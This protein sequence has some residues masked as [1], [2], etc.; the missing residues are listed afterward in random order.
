LAAM[1]SLPFDPG[2]GVAA[3]DDAGAMA[4]D[5]P[6]GWNVAVPKSRGISVCA[7]CLCEVAAGSVRV[8]TGGR[9]A[10]VHHVGCVASRLGDVSLMTGWSDL[11][12]S[13]QEAA[14]TA[15]ET[16]LGNGAGGIAAAL[17][18][19]PETEV[20]GPLL[21]T[22]QPLTAEG[23]KLLNLSFW[24]S[25]P[26]SA[27]HDPVRTGRSVPPWLHRA[28]AELRGAAA[29]ALKEAASAS[30]TEREWKALLFLDRLLFAVPA[31][32]RAGRRGQSGET[33]SQTLSR[34]LRSAWAGEWHV[35][36]QESAAAISTPGTAESRAAR[37]EVSADIR[38]IEATMAEEDVRCALRR[39]DG[40]LAFASTQDALRELPGLFPAAE[41]ALP[42]PDGRQPAALDVQ[43]FLEE[44]DKAF[45]RAP[46][47]RAPGPGGGRNEHWHFMPDYTP[48]WEPLQE[49]WLNLSLGRVPPNVLAA[50]AGARVLAGDK[51]GGKVRP[52]ALGHTLRRLLARSVARVFAGR[53]GEAVRP[54]NY[55]LGMPSGAEAM[56]KSVLCDLARR[57]AANLDSFDVT[58][59]H[60]EVERA[61]LIEAV[62]ESVPDL[63][64]WVE[65]WLR[66]EAVH[67]CHLPG[68]SPVQLRKNRGGDQGDPLINLLFPLAFHRVCLATQEVAARHDSEAHVYA[69]QDD[70]QLVATCDARPAAKAAFQAACSELGLRP[71]E[72]KEEL[73]MGPAADSVADVDCTVVSRPRVLRHGGEQEIPATRDD[74]APPGSLLADTAPE[75]AKLLANRTTFLQRLTSLHNAGLSAQLTLGLLRYRTAGDFTFLARA[76]GIPVAAAQKLDSEVLQFVEQLVGGPGWD[77]FARRR[78]FHPLKDGGL[79]IASVELVAA[80]AHSASWCGVA[81]EVVNRLGLPSVA[82]LRA[83]VP[84]AEACLAVAEAL[85]AN[86]SGDPLEPATAQTRA[87]ALSQKALT[88]ARVKN[89]VAE[90]FRQLEGDPPAAAQLHSSGG[91]GAAGW[92]LSPKRPAHYFRDEQLSVAIRLRLGLAVPCAQGVCQHVKAGGQVCGAVLDTRGLH[93][94]TCQAGG[95]SIRRHDAACKCVAA[96]AEL[97]GCSAEREVVLPLAA[98]TRP[99]ARMDVV[100]HSRTS[101]GQASNLDITVV[102]PLT[103]EMIRGGGA[104]R[105]PG[106]AARAAAAHKR[107]LYPNIPVVPFVIETF[108]RWGEDARAWALGLAPPPLLGRAEAMAGFYQ[109]VSTCRRPTPS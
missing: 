58:N 39:V 38:E 90:A 44:A 81:E 13:A 20:E 85:A 14:R 24:D 2:G 16:A 5:A 91:P 31:R 95:W 78:V 15:S 36:W 35:L 47:R 55:A 86:V 59:A 73:Y 105:N 88:Q 52:F 53:V 103:A 93:A 98:P 109:D 28:V 94:M 12:S 84:W 17:Q 92:L 67:V 56:H 54:F 80:A 50:V 37:E 104:A 83:E 100:V 4:I 6:A 89:E 42:A 64:P 19:L 106:A 26:W 62:R 71:N 8:R 66:T 29:I 34:R 46:R 87:N 101:S 11:P 61:G 99:L 65:P 82:V 49:C 69:Y 40:P 48:Q 96:Y 97:Q 10:R 75:L 45:R 9:G 22:G 33:L 41:K 3:G 7:T 57:P 43:A 70:M 27:L 79:G 76:C 30:T 63:G 25:I 108:G 1:A 32:R 102:S 18:A 68:A 21:S 77:T 74:S 23:G 72:S 60:N 51:G 107:A